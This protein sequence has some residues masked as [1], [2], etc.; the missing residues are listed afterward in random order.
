MFEKFTI[1]IQT[2]LFEQLANSCEFEDVVIGRKG[3][4][5]VDCSNDLVPIVRTTTK[6]NNPVQRFSPI[7]YDMVDAIRTITNRNDLSFNSA[8]IEIYNK[9]YRTMGF[10]S[11]QA[12][13]LAD[14]SYI[15][16]FSCYENPTDVSGVRKL[17]IRNKITSEDSEIVL[18]HNLVVLFSMETNNENTHK[19]H[20]EG[21]PSTDN[22]WLG[23]TFRLSKTFIKFI[24]EI[25][26]FYPQMD[27]VLRLANDGET[28]EFYKLRGGENSNIGF[29][30]PEIY[31]SICASD[32]LPTLN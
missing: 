7:H 9:E 32:L 27:K 5:L 3:A 13:D 4:N 11:D 28:R 22:R 29:D 14:G 26:Y 23:I 17:K 21:N 31:Y 19:I 16:V 18:S 12:L 30:Y 2:N 15:C 1:D 25:P 8:L 10:H 20:L 24:N 6:Y